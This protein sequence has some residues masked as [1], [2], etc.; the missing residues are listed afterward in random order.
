MKGII[1]ITALACLAF[2]CKPSTEELPR[3]AGQNAVA[4]STQEVTVESQAEVVDTSSAKATAEPQ[5][6]LALDT[7]AMAL[8]ETIGSQTVSFT[9][10]QKSWPSGADLQERSK[11]FMDTGFMKDLAPFGLA[12]LAYSDIALDCIKD[13]QGRI[14]QLNGVSS[15][16]YNKYSFVIPVVRRRVD[17]ISGSR[18]VNWEDIIEQIDQLKIGRAHV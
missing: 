16:I 17:A 4:T 14:S 13:D 6:E 5:T 3:A 1:M 15:D 9:K 10:L 12:D 2:A 7:P 8:T 18:Q 11:G